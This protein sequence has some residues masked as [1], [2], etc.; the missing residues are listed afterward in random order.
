MSTRAGAC[1]CVCVYGSHASEYTNLGMYV[2]ENVGVDR[3]R[4]ERRRRR[5][6]E[7]RS[8]ERGRN[9]SGSSG[10]KAKGSKSKAVGLDGPCEML[11]AANIYITPYAKPVPS[12]LYI[13]TVLIFIISEVGT[14]IT[15]FYRWRN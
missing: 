4:E 2:C 10:I 14:L 13:L 5:R 12:P 15:P 7:R 3:E 1:V 8:K 11:I 9:L 6:R